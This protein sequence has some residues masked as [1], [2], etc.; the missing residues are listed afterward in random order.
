MGNEQRPERSS[1]SGR[2]LAPVPRGIEVLVHKAA[3]DAEFRA[4]LLERRAGAASEINLQLSPAEGLML[5]GIPAAQLEAV[6]AST[7][8]SPGNRRAFLG[9]AASAMLAALTA[10]GALAPQADAGPDRKVKCYV[11]KV[12]NHKGET[13]IK[14]C[15]ASD[16]KTKTGGAAKANSLMR[17]AYS[18]ARTEWKDDPEHK[19]V[20]FPMK[21]PK[22]VA[23]KRLGTYHSWREAEGVQRRLQAELDAEIKKQDEARRRQLEA[24]PEAARARAQREAELLKQ[25]LEIFE[26]H[27]QRLVQ[28]VRQRNKGGW[29]GISTFGTSP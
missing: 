21:P 13:N 7:K 4:L 28:T 15:L 17:R 14:M 22:S 11:Y 9:R 20:D 29:D 24:L 26:A 16:Y 3:V 18:L 25:A 6:I 1:G 8:V 10:S 19:G 27:Y 12:R 23:S 2:N 5:D